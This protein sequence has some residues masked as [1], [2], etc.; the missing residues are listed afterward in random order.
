MLILEHIQERARSITRRIGLADA[1]DPRMLEAARIATDAGIAEI[2]LVGDSAA[3]QKALRAAKIEAGSMAVVDPAEYC[4]MDGLATS[5][6]TRLHQPM[7]Q[8]DAISTIRKNPLLFGALLVSA[9]DI[10]GLLGGSLSTTGDIIRAALKGIGLAPGRTVL[11]SMFLM[12]FPSI[13]GFR[14]E[15]TLGFGDCAVIPDPTPEQLRDIAIASSETYRT[16]TGNASRTALLS[17][18]T[19]G[20]AVT[21]STEKMIAATELL[22]HS[23]DLGFLFDGELQFDAAFVPSV[24]AKKAVGSSLEGKANV[25]IFPNLDAGNIGYKIAERLGMG[26]AVGPIMQGLAKPMNDLSRGTTVSEIV[27][28]IAVTALQSVTAAQ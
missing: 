12:A 15:F 16:L 9:G 11:S 7:S 26:Q 20:S 17:F 6:N 8:E 10:D 14:E 21:S 2:C 22:K 13:E 24:A 25:F 4:E 23:G 3:I 18:S 5:F 19:K 1:T 28:M 27:T